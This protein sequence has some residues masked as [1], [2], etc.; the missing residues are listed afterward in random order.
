MILQ[1]FLFDFDE[2]FEKLISFEPIKSSAEDGSLLSELR[3]SLFSSC[4]VQINI[5]ISIELIL[6]NFTKIINL[7]LL[8]VSKEWKKEKKGEENTI[9]YQWTSSP[10]SSALV[11]IYYTFCWMNDNKCYSN[12]K[13]IHSSRNKSNHGIVALSTQKSLAISIAILTISKRNT[14]NSDFIYIF[15]F[16]PKIK[17]EMRKEK[18]KTWEL[19]A[20]PLLLK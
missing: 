5:P 2:V 6:W 3:L 11:K 13:S 4:L 19:C 16:P 18:R 1:K 12:E 17:I 7:Q 20:L 8:N 14:I 10:L 9:R 15:P